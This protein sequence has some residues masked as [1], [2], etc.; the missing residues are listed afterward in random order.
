MFKINLKTV[1]FL[2][3][4]KTFSLINIIGLAIGTLCCLYIVLYVQDQYSYD[5]HHRNAQNLYRINAIIMAQNEKSNWATVTAPVAPTMKKDFPEVEEYA[6]YS[7][8]GM[9]HHLLR[10]KDKSVY[11]NEERHGPTLPF[12]MFDFHFVHG[13]AEMALSQPQ[14]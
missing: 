10:Y 14:L 9:D 8:V 2:Q 5:K 3:K 11:E 7:G 1:P 6:A 4:N 13:S 12:R